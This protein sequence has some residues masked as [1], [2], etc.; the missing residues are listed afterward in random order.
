MPVISITHRG[1]CPLTLAT[2]TPLTQKRCPGV[3]RHKRS[4]PQR[5]LHGRAGGQ[6]IHTPCHVTKE[7][8]LIRDN[9]DPPTNSSKL[10]HLWNSSLGADTAKLPEPGWVLSLAAGWCRGYSGF[11]SPIILCLDFSCFSGRKRSPTRPRPT[12]LLCS[13]SLRMLTVPPHGILGL[14]FH[15]N[16]EQA[17][18]GREQGQ[19]W[20]RQR[21]HVHWALRS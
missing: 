4:K 15:P 3:S 20:G 13:P 16:S 11:L 12:L 2:S 17:G 14:A 7:H 19:S 6:L 21:T 9:A 10:I 5:A 1:T 18:Q 8:G